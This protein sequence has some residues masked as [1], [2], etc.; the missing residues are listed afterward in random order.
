MFKS[1]IIAEPDKL[2]ITIKRVFNAPSELVFTMYTDPV[3]IP[4]W[5]GP[6]YLTTVVETMDVRKGGIWRYIQG[7]AAGNEHAFNGVYHEITSPRRI[8]RTFEYEGAPNNVLLETV[9]LEQL[10]NGQTKLTAQSVFQT[11]E[12]RNAMLQSGAKAGGDE[13]MERLAELLVQAQN[14]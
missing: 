14:Q 6:R 10:P 11:L 4:K 7:D 13:S 9:T 2:E 8:V 1:E 3:A 12:A 5:W